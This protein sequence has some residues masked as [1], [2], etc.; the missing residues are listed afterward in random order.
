MNACCSVLAIFVSIFLNLFIWE[1]GQ[2]IAQVSL[3]NVSMYAAWGAA[4]TT[5]AKWLARHT[6]R[7]P[8][9]LS[10][11]SG[12]AAFAFLGWVEMDNQ[13]VWLLLL[14]LPVGCM[15][16]FSQAS[17]NL[18]VA[19]RGKGG[20]FAAYF[21]TAAIII[22]LLS[23]AVPIASARMID[24]L[25][26]GGSFAVMLAFAVLTLAFS[27]AMPAIRMPPPD[28]PEESREFGKF[29]FRTAFGS[30][31]SGWILL[32]LLFSG[33]F[34]QFQNLFTLLFTFS[35]TQDKLLIALLNVLYSVA[36]LAGLAAY[37]KFRLQDG[38]WLWVGTWLLAVGFFIVLFRSPAAFIVSNV[39]TTAGMFFFSTV[40][41]AQQFRFMEDGGTTRKASFLVWRECILI[42][43]RCM[44]LGLTFPLKELSGGWFA[45]LIGLILLCLFAI[46]VFQHR[47]E[48]A[49][50]EQRQNSLTA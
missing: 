34:L 8:L 43:T 46:P 23:V 24:G 11:V 25:G 41:N 2:S 20:D 17:Q 4:F 10:A 9:A 1:N 44:L 12:G 42:A 22:Q 33:M 45:G 16:G 35:V 32:S 3:Y 49:R 7:L 37:R 31:G 6:I 48:R 36:A 38:R 14:G 27:A 30:P 5:A 15:F 18:G 39:M 47:A 19:L 50:A 26:Y 13:T 28:T 29:R 21:G 40:W